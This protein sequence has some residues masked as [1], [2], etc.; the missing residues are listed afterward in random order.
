MKRAARV[1]VKLRP[2]RLTNRDWTPENIFFDVSNSVGCFTNAE[3]LL[4]ERTIDDMI[5]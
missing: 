5:T 1:R 3:R 2:K 4:I